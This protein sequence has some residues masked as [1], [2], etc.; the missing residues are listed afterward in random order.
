M[1][2]ANSSPFAK[3]EI[4]RR[5]REVGEEKKV[6]QL[7]RIRFSC[8]LKYVYYEYYQLYYVK[9]QHFALKSYFVSVMVLLPTD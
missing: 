1:T 7:C 9:A 3:C 6:F 5:T 8:N 4:E 2:C